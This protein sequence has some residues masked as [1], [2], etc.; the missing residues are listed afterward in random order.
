MPLSLEYGDRPKLSAGV[1]IVHRYTDTYRYLLLR[2]YRYWDFPKGLVEPG[3]TPLDAAR[4]EVHEETALVH[5]EFRWGHH[6]IETEPYGD[7]KIARYYLAES[8]TIDVTL[9]RSRALGRPEHHEYRWVDY[10][11]SRNLVGARVRA[12]LD[13]AQQ[14]LSDQ[15]QRV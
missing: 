8:S 11:G 1:V 10:L 6:Y 5:L 12:V 2:I 3:E 7:S 4:R 15:V 9:P 13:W 14:Q